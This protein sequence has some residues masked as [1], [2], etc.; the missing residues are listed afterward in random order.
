MTHIEIRAADAARATSFWHGLFGWDFNEVP[1]G[2]AQ[3]HIT[4]IGE[5]QSGAVT[6]MPVAPATR[7]Y[8]AVDDITGA[9]A[10]VR[11][12]GGEA[13]DPIPVPSAGSFATCRDPEGNDFGLWQRA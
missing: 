4:Q 12:L 5:Q 7:T 6:A 9:V 1:G 2:P 11:E 13:A 8:F 3:Y 10:R